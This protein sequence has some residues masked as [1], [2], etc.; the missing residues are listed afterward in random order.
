[1]AEITA[2]MVKELRERTGAGMGDCKAALTEAN[3]DMN[4]A[5]EILRRKGAAQ[6]AKRAERVAKEGIVSTAVS[7]DHR[8]GVIAEI[9]CETDFVARNQNFV[10]FSQ[11]VV[12]TL[13]NNDVNS[14]EE[15]LGAS[16]NGEKVGD[17]FNEVLAKFQENIQIRRFETIKTNGF[18]ADYVHAGSKLGVLVEFNFDNPITVS[19][20]FY[21]HFRD[22][23]MQ[24][25]ALNPMFIDRTSVGNDV[26]QK[27]LDIYK[28]LAI[29][30][31]KKPEI[32]ERI[33]T[34]KLEKF[35]Q[36]QC[37]LEQAFIKDDS[38]TVKEYLD[39]VAKKLG[40]EIKI[41]QFRRYNLG[42]V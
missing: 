25:A 14:L 41:A 37:L 5:I 13:L 31:G 35:F 17:L 11:I 32:A 28:E 2:Q 7:D 23:A 34:G 16:Y 39:F 42:E 15:L 20:E 36:E 3:G 22:I 21:T 9:N 29:K 19:E 33:A 40:C 6:A 30:E 26:I 1:M 4:A 10:D 24:I 27:E 18:I 8:K 12:K 38:M